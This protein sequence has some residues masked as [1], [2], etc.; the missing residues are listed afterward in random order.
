MASSLADES[1]EGPR[2]RWAAQQAVGG[3][4]TLGVHSHGG[5][6][7]LE[8]TIEDVDEGHSRLT[9]SWP[10]EGAQLAPM[11]DAGR[12]LVVRV[13]EA[14]GRAAFM[15]VLLEAAR[16]EEP[17]RLLVRVVTASSQP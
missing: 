4:V 13:A 10:T 12:H 2:P 14:G 16:F 15:D 11:R 9:L 7:W 1:A 6:Q 8:S 17:P 5:W 3:A